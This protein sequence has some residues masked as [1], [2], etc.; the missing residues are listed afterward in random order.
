MNK[1]LLIGAALLGAGVLAYKAYKKSA[2]PT[3]P[4]TPTTPNVGTPNV[5]LTKGQKLQ[6]V[7]RGILSLAQMVANYRAAHPKKA[8]TPAFSMTNPTYNA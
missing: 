8:T 7:G 1:K 5:P 4:T 6:N 3:Q 2:E